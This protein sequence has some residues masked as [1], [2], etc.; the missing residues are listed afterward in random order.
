VG[1]AHLSIQDD[2]DAGEYAVLVRSDVKGRGLGWELMKS[3]REYAGRAG[4][5]AIRGQV[6][7]ENTTMIRMCQELGFNISPDPSDSRLRLVTL[8]V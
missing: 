3:L 6:L 7:P 5:S 4:L 1:L 2:D 8:P